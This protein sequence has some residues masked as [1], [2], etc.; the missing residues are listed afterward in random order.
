M[1]ISEEEEQY[2]FSE[3]SLAAEFAHLRPVED[4]KPS[5]IR[6]IPGGLGWLKNNDKEYKKNKKQNAA[7]NGRREARDSRETR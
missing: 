7:K 1:S 3:E 2:T 4:E 5:K 6:R